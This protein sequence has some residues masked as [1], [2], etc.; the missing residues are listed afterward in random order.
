MSQHSCMFSAHA[1]SD[2]NLRVSAACVRRDLCEGGG[3]TASALKSECVCF[4]TA[5]SP[6]LFFWCAWPYL[7]VWCEQFQPI[8][9]LWDKSECGGEDGGS[10]QACL[11]V[12]F[13]GRD[14]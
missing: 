6:I 12:V 14:H 11:G 9:W 13:R 3:F 5:T 10:W 1:A 8:R 7:G 4:L 2:S